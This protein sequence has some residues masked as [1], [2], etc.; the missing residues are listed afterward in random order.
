MDKLSNSVGNKIFVVLVINSILLF[1]IILQSI[2]PSSVSALS[3]TDRFKLL[4]SVKDNWG[5]TR[6]MRFDDTEI[7][8]IQTR[9]TDGKITGFTMIQN[10]VGEPV[11]FDDAGNM[12]PRIEPEREKG[13]ADGNGRG[14]T[15]NGK[16]TGFVGPYP[17]DLDYYD[18]FEFTFDWEEWE[19][20]NWYHEDSGFKYD[21]NGMYEDDDDNPFKREHTHYDYH[22]GHASYDAPKSP[23]FVTYAYE[24]VP[25]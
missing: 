16:I 4:Y 14:R 20:T 15:F 5:E 24:M 25:H 13:T 7:G 12:L 10:A 2:S 11:R 18:E 17:V 1:I 3:G 21:H 22:T 23:P 9:D 8:Y 19:R 6:I